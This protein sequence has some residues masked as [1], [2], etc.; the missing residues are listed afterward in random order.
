[1]HIKRRAVL[2]H[3]R[4][5]FIWVKLVPDEIRSIDAKVT[6]PY[7]RRDKPC[8]DTEERSLPP[9]VK[10][11]AQKQPTHVGPIRRE[12][13]YNRTVGSTV[14]SQRVDR[15]VAV[16]E[17]V[18]QSLRYQGSIDIELNALAKLTCQT[19]TALLTSLAMVRTGILR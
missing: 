14:C 8:G 18:L 3:L 6:M 13:T 17:D 2:W 10:A 5:E 12:A 4:C 15:R 1:M 11:Q 16:R 7:T 9:S 19:L